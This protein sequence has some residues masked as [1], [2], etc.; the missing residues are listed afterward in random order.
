MTS[1]ALGELVWFLAVVT[2]PS[3][4]QALVRGIAILG[5]PFWG[6]YDKGILPFGGQR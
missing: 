2:C 3:A 4:I 1:Q 5:V 6:P